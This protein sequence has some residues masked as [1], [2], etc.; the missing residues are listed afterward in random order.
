M[1]GLKL[2]YSAVVAAALGLSGS[3]AFAQ[4]FDTA[5]NYSSS[6]WG[7]STPTANL[8]TGFG[9]WTFVVQNNTMPP[10]AGGYLD[11]S[12]AVTSG[13][14]SWGIYANN[15]G[16]IPVIDAI[17]PFAG[18]PLSNQTF[19]V[20]LASDGIGYGNGGAPPA[21][22]F[23]FSLERAGG[24]G[25]IGPAELTLE[26]SGTLGSDNLVL[27]DNNG[28]TN[29]SVNINFG[30]LNTGINVAVTVGGNPSGANPYSVTITPFNGGTPVTLTGSSTGP[31]AQ[32]DVFDSDTQ[33]ND[34]F[35]N[36]SIVSV[37]EP[38]SIAL[39]GIGLLGALA[40]RRRDA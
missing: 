38:S 37:P 19:S 13:G 36:L 32:V 2:A 24:A 28:T 9:D 7:P 3:I 31:M 30:E 29:T 34:Y 33:G 11:V 27:E 22:A 1:M 10:Y 15:P 23:G 12:S 35:N 39:V 5:S 18:G 4:A 25:G 20:N 16:Q 8:G 40:L 17:R 26:Y 21:A 14:Y 6:G